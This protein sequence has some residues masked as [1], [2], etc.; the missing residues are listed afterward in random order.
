MARH[1]TW[2]DFNQTNLY[3]FSMRIFANC[4]ISRHP[5]FTLLNSNRFVLHLGVHY[6]SQ[7]SNWEQLVPPITILDVLIGI[8]YSIRVTFFEENL[9][10]HTS[11]N[12][13]TLKTPNPLPQR[14]LCDLC[15]FSICSYAKPPNLTLARL[16]GSNIAD[17]HTHTH[18]DICHDMWAHKRVE[19]WPVEEL[20][21]N[22]ASVTHLKVTFAYSPNKDGT[23][24]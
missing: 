17:A 13:F 3:D 4:W 2:E 10:N 20:C 5:L 21:V 24:R 6:G 14:Q 15:W 22:F 8:M 1:S 9:G 7:R 18:N 19:L 11:N 16:G 23:S 12:P